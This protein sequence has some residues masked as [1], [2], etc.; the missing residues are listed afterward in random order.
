M[1][2][3][4]KIKAAYEVEKMQKK[5]MGKFRLWWWIRVDMTM[6]WLFKEE[7]MARLKL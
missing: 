7:N 3:L 4:G 1:W 5:A 6:A 2:S